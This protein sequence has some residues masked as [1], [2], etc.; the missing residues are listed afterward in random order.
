MAAIYDLNRPNPLA[1]PCDPESC[2][3]PLVKILTSHE[4]SQLTHI[5]PEARAEL[6]ALELAAANFVELYP[7]YIIGSFSVPDKSD[8]TG[9]PDTMSFYLE[10]DHLILIDDGRHRAEDPGQSGRH[11]HPHEAH[12][13][14][15]P[16]CLHEDAHRRR[17]QLVLL[18]GRRHGKPRGRHDRPPCRHLVADHHELP[19]RRHAHGLLLPAD[20]RHGR[21]HRRQ[22][23]QGHE[24]RGGPDLPGTSPPTRITCPTAPTCCASTACSFTSCIRRRST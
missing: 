10:A 19:A 3:P 9:D 12:H 24:P 22:R 2:K 21:P 20:R 14:A 16:V 6:A 15:Y 4:F 8:P 1:A 13:L 17:F 7:S 23:E 11:G 5:A 18:H